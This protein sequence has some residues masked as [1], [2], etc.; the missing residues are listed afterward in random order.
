MLTNSR[1]V[2]GILVVL[3]VSTD[4]RS[5][6]L[7]QALQDTAAHIN[8]GTPRPIGN[9]TSLV[10]AV[11]YE[12]TLKYK[13]TFHRLTKEEITS[14]FALKQTEFLTDFVC[15]RPD[16][17]AFVDNGVTL[18]YAYHDKHGKLV[19]VVTVDTKTCATE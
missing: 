10:G 9:D 15:T 6:N 5:L 4:V 11:A 3:V 16:M 18:K 7:E 2:A 19:V 1:K 8:K 12:K 13:F 17:K 14:Q